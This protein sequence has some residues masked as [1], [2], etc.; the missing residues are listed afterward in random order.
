MLFETQGE[1]F[2]LDEEEAIEFF[3]ELAKQLEL[4]EEQFAAEL[5]EG[6]YSE[7]VQQ[8]IEEAANLQL[9][10]TP[11]ALVDG[12]LVSSIPDLPV[13]QQYIDERIIVKALEARQYNAAPEMALE[14]DKRYTAIVEMESGGTFTIELLPDSAPQ[15]V[16]SFI[17]L[18]NEGWFDNVMFH[19]VVPGFV[20][21]T[22]D[23]TGTGQG[24]PG[25]VIPN[26]ID[27]NLSHDAAG[28]V[29]MANRGPDT[30]GSQWYITLADN[31]PSLLN[32]DGSY[33]IFGRIAEG[34]EVVQ[35]ITPRDPQNPA[36]PPGDFIKTITIV[37]D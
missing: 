5:S 34:M 2:D 1:W 10:G 6:K 4:D 25:Y 29:A 9:P 3:I 37:V 24:G 14:E 22:G 7:Y 23:P 31:D 15:T 13:W 12:R 19:R 35:G 27:P 26:E 11:A 16:N 32:L 30:N 36:A 20:A 21:Q 8:M 28:M 18:A 17:F 33:T